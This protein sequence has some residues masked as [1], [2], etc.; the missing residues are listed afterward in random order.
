MKRWLRVVSS[1]SILMAMLLS[2]VQ[3]SA[4][5][6]TITGGVADAAGTCG[7]TDPAFCDTFSQPA[8]TG[9]RAGQLNGTIWGASRA[10]GNNNPSQGE[11]DAWSPTQLA[12]CG[13]PLNVQPDNDIIVC[14]G[15]VR[16]ATNDNETVTAL[17]MYPKQPFDFT[18]R[19]GIVTFDVSN[20]TQGSHAA[21][22]EFWLTDKPI[23]A[24]FTHFGTWMAVP[25]HG[26]GLRFY[27]SQ[28]PNKGALLAPACPNDGNT[29]WTVGSAVVV[30]NYVVDDQ[31]NNGATKVTPL[32]CVTASSGP[33]GGLNHI[34][35]NISQSQ[36]DI[37]ATDAGTTGPLHHIGVVQNANLTLTH[38][39]IWLLDAHYNGGKF[40]SQAVHTFSWANVGFDG[41]SLARD[42]AFDVPDNQHVNGD[43]TINLGWQVNPSSPPALTVTGVSN[44]QAAQAALLTANVSVPTAPVTFNYTVNGHAHTQ[45]WPFPDTASLSWRS[46]ALPVPLSDIVAGTNMLTLSA[47]QPIQVANVDLILVGAGGVA[48]GGGSSGS[49]APPPQEP[50]TSTLTPTVTTTSTPTPRAS[51][52]ATRTPTPTSPN[53]TATPAGTSFQLSGRASPAIVTRGGT[54]TFNLSVTSTRGVRALVDLEVFATSGVKVYQRYWDDQ[55]FAPGQTLSYSTNWN[56]PANA[57]SGTYS[58]KV[59]VFSV[60]WGTLFGWN[61]SAAALTI[62]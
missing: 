34:Q 47:T 20:D 24:P 25:Q 19:T 50:A 57:A 60:G 38:G 23:P 32:D 14:N 21:W 46:V 45:A 30:R 3:T 7:M 8:G 6:V 15:Q 58:V 56:V 11:V 49:Q 22:P 40:N 53:A 18:N 51:A 54:E 55:G 10:T 17:A 27:S 5:G 1:I 13:G 48:S 62:Q 39:L 33:N 31:D 35:L 41:P 59:A 26:F 44:I 12:G 4:G 16:E 42:L 29:R 2:M 36:I 9:N 43:G 61:N 52:T 28:V 37:Y